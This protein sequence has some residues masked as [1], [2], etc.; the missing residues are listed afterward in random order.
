[1]GKD[2]NNVYDVIHDLTECMCAELQEDNAAAAAAANKLIQ[3]I[4]LISGIRNQFSGE[5]SVGVGERK[6]EL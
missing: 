1:M 5:G 2:C 4:C 6:L 3:V